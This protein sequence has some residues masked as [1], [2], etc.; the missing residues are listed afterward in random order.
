FVDLGIFRP[1]RPPWV[2]E[3][4]HGHIPNSLTDFEERYRLAVP[5]AI[6]SLSVAGLCCRSGADAA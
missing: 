1:H 5:R 3:N 4:T 6:N 2:F